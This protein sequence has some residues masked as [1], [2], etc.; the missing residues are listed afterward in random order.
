[1]RA[2]QWG[3]LKTRREGIGKAGLVFR[4]SPISMI[5]AFLV[6]L[7]SGIQAYAVDDPQS[8][9]APSNTA[10]V[11]VDVEATNASTAGISGKM[12]DEKLSFKPSPS[13]M[14]AVIKAQ[15]GAQTLVL[16]SQTDL[17]A[18][19]SVTFADA[20]NVV[21]SEHSQAV[22]LKASGTPTPVPPK[23]D[24]DSDKNQSGGNTGN[25]NN[26]GSDTDGGNANTNMPNG[27]VRHD[28]SNSNTNGNT[29][30]VV[31]TGA[32]ISGIAM[33]AIILAVT[34]VVAMRRKHTDHAQ[35][36]A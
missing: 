16:Q 8:F 15:A 35:R 29:L 3:A 6:C 2:F 23:G 28:Q 24:D 34:G 5:L 30:N 9:E 14:T 4:I 10:Q 1:M 21:L 13:G 12:S 32:A 11:W 27:T 26:N 36:E 7:T 33:L 25:S 31:K 22:S 17:D 19:L 18:R 20:N